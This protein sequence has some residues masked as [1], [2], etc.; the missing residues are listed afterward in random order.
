MKNTGSSDV[1]IDNILLNGKPYTQIGGVYVTWLPLYLPVG[2]EG[3]ITIA[4]A[5][6]GSFV[7]GVTVEVQLHS[8]SGRE[9]PKT[10]ILP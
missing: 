8:A 5:K 1:L 3:T 7:P 10:I 4:I 6:G 9:Y 2:T